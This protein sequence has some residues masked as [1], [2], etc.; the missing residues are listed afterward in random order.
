MRERLQS[1]GYRGEQRGK[2]RLQEAHILGDSQ[3]PTNRE[4]MND[5]RWRPVYKSKT[6][7]AMGHGVMMRGQGAGAIRQSGQKRGGLKQSPKG[8]KRG[9]VLG[10]MLWR[11]AT[12]RCPSSGQGA[13]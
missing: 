1:P 2:P 7:K 6:E 12:V 4:Y 8:I 11:D 5:A 13:L 3:P 9:V 10:T